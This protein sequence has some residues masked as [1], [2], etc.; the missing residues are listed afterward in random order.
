M[1]ACWEL[2]WTGSGVIPFP[3]V[4]KGLGSRGERH[5]QC[6]LERQ[7]GVCHGS[8]QTELFLITSVYTAPMGQCYCAR[9]QAVLSKHTCP[10]WPKD[11]VEGLTPPLIPKGARPPQLE[12]WG[13]DFFYKS[14]FWG[15][16]PRQGPQTSA[17]VS[18]AGGGGGA[19]SSGQ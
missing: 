19:A 18:E 2:P 15:G 16:V 10:V 6:D 8:R 12:T 14:D 4:G 13:Q 7:R 17:R 1:P 11:S 5:L 3:S 9:H